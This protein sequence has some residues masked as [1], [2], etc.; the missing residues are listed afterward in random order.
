MRPPNPEKWPHKR[1]PRTPP[2]SSKFGGCSILSSR[3]PAAFFI[4]FPASAR[5]WI[6][7]PGL[8]LRDRRGLGLRRLAARELQRRHLFFFL[9]LDVSR[10]V[11]HRVLRRLPLHV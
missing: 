8:F 7:A 5:A 3:R 2:P 10:Q 1:R 9:S 6:V 11:E 4:F